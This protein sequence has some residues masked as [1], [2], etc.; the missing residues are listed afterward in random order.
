MQGRNNSVSGN[1]ADEGDFAE[2]WPGRAQDCE[3]NADRGR[4]SEHDRNIELAPSSERQS[5]SG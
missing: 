5:D 3:Q 2:R 1:G 4:E